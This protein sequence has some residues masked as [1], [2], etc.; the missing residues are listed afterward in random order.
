MRAARLE[1]ANAIQKFLVEGTRLGF[2]ALPH[3]EALHGLVAPRGEQ[4]SPGDRARG[5][6]RSEL[7]EE[8]FNVTARPGPWRGG[9]SMCLAPVLDVAR[10]PAWGRIEETYGE[11]PSGHR[12]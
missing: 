4:F 9:C 7:V 8:V 10:D 3:E 2:P 11:N 5:H 12:A 1:F 6:L